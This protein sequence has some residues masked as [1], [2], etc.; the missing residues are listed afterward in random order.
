[1]KHL[2]MGSMWKTIANKNIEADTVLHESVMIL[3]VN[4]CNLH[5]RFCRGG[6]DEKLLKD[7]SSV[8]TMSTDMFKRIIDKCT[9]SNIS[10]I[11]LTP[12]IGENMLDVDIFSKL[13][14]LESHDKIESFIFTTNFI[15]VSAEDMRRFSKYK[16]MKL[17]ISVYGFDSKSYKHS[18]NRDKFE[19]FIENL[20]VLYDI[21]MESPMKIQFNDRVDIRGTIMEDIL[22]L[23]FNKFG[24]KML[25]EEHNSNRAGHVNIE[26]DHVEKRSGVCPFGP[27]SGG[28][29]DQYGNVLFCSFSDIK[30]E[31]IVGNIFDKSLSEIYSGEKF[32]SIIENHESGN[33]IGICKNC[34]EVW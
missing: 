29:I 8:K 21:C 34:T 33:Y 5:C 25:I 12:S 28:G 18:T 27:G 2:N 6:M 30:K 31:G 26:S 32:K 9:E 1:M 15:D 24:I 20:D 11:D 14:Y 4:K 23:F 3:I 13:D 7:Q 19:K 16:K 17:S 10:K 22:F